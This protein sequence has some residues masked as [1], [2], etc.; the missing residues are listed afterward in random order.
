M[1]ITEHWK[2]LLDQ[3]YL[4]INNS[5]DELNNVLKAVR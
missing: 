5:H 4:G 3:A 1:L 2:D